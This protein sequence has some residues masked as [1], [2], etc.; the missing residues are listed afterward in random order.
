MVA[1][2]EEVRDEVRD[3]EVGT[4]FGEFAGSVEANGDDAAGEFSGV[5]EVITCDEDG[6]GGREGNGFG[7][8]EDAGIEFRG[9]SEA[10]EVMGVNGWT[11]VINDGGGG[12]FEEEGGDMFL[13]FFL[14]VGHG[15]NDGI[16][17]GADYSGGPGEEGL[18]GAWRIGGDAE[19]GVR[20]RDGELTGEGKDGSE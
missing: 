15:G 13:E 20:G 4:F 12:A 1:V 2:V 7:D 11:G 16:A 5:G 18:A 17:S 8:T 10:F 3:G 6:G 9:G 14:G 19:D